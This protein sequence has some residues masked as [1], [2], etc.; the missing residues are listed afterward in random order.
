MDYLHNLSVG[1]HYSLHRVSLFFFFFVVVGL[2]DS[3]PF[4]SSKRAFGTP[5]E[6]EVRMNNGLGCMQ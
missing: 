4:P 2:Q 1:K 3:C 6:P 5:D